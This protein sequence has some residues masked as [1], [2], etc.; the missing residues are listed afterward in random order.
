M[1]VAF[2]CLQKYI[3]SYEREF[4]VAC[5]ARL[6]PIWSGLLFRRLRQTGKSVYSNSLFYYMEI[7]FNFDCHCKYYYLNRL[8]AQPTLWLVGWIKSL[9]NNYLWF[10]A[11]RAFA[12]VTLVGEFHLVTGQT[13]WLFIPQHISLAHQRAVTAGTHCH[14]PYLMTFSFSKVT[15]SIWK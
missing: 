7:L 9:S 4:G 15:S 11:N 10:C 12:C 5:P 14:G 1:E 2:L 6:C 8:L 3:F 13:C